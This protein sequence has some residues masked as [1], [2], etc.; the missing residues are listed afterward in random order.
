MKLLN[1]ILVFSKPKVN[2][3]ILLYLPA[4]RDSEWVTIDHSVVT[5]LPPSDWVPE[6]V[7]IDHSAI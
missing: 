1:K 4:N 7:T 6:W 3:M 5:A 2:G